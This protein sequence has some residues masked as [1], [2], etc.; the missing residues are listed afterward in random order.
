[1]Q[2]AA[3]ARALQGTGASRRLRF[4]GKTPA[5][6]YG[7]GAAPQSIELDHNMLFH[8]LK[9]ESFHSDILQLDV[10]GQTTPVVLR[11]VQYHPFKPQILH[12]DFQR[13][14]ENTKVE[15]KVA[16]VY[17]GVE[18]SPA[19]KDDNCTITT[20]LQ[21]LAVVCV[22]AKRPEAIKVD[23]SGLTVKSNLGLHHLVKLPVG[24]KAVVRGSNKNPN[25]V[26]IKLPEVAPDANAAAAAPAAAP[27]KKGKK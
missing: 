18:N 4:T 24:V 19:V 15:A 13:V 12:V 26:S 20:L 3:T 7:A 25:L 27:A 6:V 16:L 1:M 11:A 2:I 8:A 10:D 23:L 14:D 9:K 21:E 5:V 17:E 22:P